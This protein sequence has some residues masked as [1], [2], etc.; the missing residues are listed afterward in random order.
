MKTANDDAAPTSALFNADMEAAGRPYTLEPY[1]GPA[2]LW[3]MCSTISEDAV[4]TFW[5]TSEADAVQQARAWLDRTTRRPAAPV[6]SLSAWR[7]A[8]AP[9]SAHSV[10]R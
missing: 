6:V 4:T 5:A 9:F 2:G 1:H 10:D 3:G 7:G 8:E